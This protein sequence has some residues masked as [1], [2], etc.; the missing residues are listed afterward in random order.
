MVSHVLILIQNLSP[1]PE[2]CIIP[3]S[4]P[5]PSPNTY[6]LQN[7]LSYVGKKENKT[8][9]VINHNYNACIGKAQTTHHMV[10]LIKVCTQH[11][12]LGVQ[13]ETQICLLMS[14][15]PLSFEIRLG[16]QKKIH[17][18]KSDNKKAH[19][20]NT[21]GKNILFYI[22]A[23]GLMTKSFTTNVEHLLKTCL[24]FILEK[25]SL[26]TIV[27]EGGVQPVHVIVL[28][29][30]YYGDIISINAVSSALPFPDTV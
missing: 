6:S 8:D 5:S 3:G 16:C 7:I 23:S 13:D 28:S 29:M 15:S 19:S 25:S 9:P 20:A 27:G 4:C 10:H 12:D 22:W 30:L 21:E 2:H 26:N 17:N 18:E 1:D 11:H 24:V 14:S